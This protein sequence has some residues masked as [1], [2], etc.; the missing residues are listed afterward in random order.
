MRILNP[1][2]GFAL[3]A[4]KAEESFLKMC[5]ALTSVGEISSCLKQDAE[6]VYQGLISPCLCG[7]AARMG[8]QVL[9]FLTEKVESPS[10]AGLALS[11]PPSHIFPS[12]FSRA[13]VRF[14]NNAICAHGL[15][16]HVALCKCKSSILATWKQ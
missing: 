1:A 4:A 6:V 7:L 13:A 15:P 8:L 3:E 11:D 12:G 5:V 16:Q 2:A 10:C 14:W 9:N